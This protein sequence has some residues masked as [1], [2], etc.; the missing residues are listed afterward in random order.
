M[1]RKISILVFFVILSNL[2]G[3]NNSAQS[4]INSLQQK[5][6]TIT[7]LKADFAQKIIPSS[8]LQGVNLSGKFYYRQNGKYRIEVNKKTLLCD[9]NSVFN[10]DD[11]MKKVVISPLDETSSLFS[12]DKIIYEFPRK[13]NLFFT[14]ENNLKTIEMLPKD[15]LLPFKKAFLQINSANLIQKIR[16]IDLADNQTIIELEGIIINSNIP[17]S[18]FVFSEQKGFE[19]VDLR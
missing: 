11:K 3:Q 16:I 4:F 15:G 14:D 1:I 13:C 12:I 8:A 7:D 2:Y 17:E 9:G 19:I 18:K 5:F 6:K 10:I